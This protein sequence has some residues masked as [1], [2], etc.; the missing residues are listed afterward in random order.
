VHDDMPCMD[1]DDLRRGKP[2]THKQFDD[3]TAL[4]AGD[5]LQSLAFD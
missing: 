2:S 1:D 4:L 3:A 5:A